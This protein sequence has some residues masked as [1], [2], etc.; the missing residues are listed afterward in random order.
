M[1]RGFGKR[2][3]VLGPVGQ[4][5]LLQGTSPQGR[6]RQG[7]T[8]NPGGLQEADAQSPR[9]VCSKAQ[10]AMASG[11]G[12]TGSDKRS[13]A[14]DPIGMFSDLNDPSISLPVGAV[15]VCTEVRLSFYFFSSTFLF[16]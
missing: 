15:S 7:P 16:F 5:A 12:N 11:A 13:E 10:W 14:C 1:E 2:S 8:R 9:A 3:A 6:P 4:T